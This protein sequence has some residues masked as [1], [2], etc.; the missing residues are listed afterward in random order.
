FTAMGFVAVTMGKLFGDVW[1]GWPWIIAAVCLLM[2]A[3][4]WD[5]WAFSVPE[6]FRAMAP[7]EGGMLSAF[8]LGL[9]FGVVS[10]PC[11]APILVVVLTYI[12]SKGNMAYGLA[13][14]WTYAIGHCL[15]IVVAGTSVGV[16][17]NLVASRS[18]QRANTIFKR[19]AGA[20]IALVGLYILKASFYGY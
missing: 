13:L 10:A 14:L 4:L 17:K 1:E 6:R 18:F 20:L 3:H 11:A 15:L 8:L 9:L 5:L 7:Q 12:A 19:V 2:A 16:A